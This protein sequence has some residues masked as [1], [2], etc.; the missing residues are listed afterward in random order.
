MNLSWVMPAPSCSSSFAAK[1]ADCVGGRVHCWPSGSP[2]TIC[3]IAFRLVALKI[4]TVLE[5]KDLNS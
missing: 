2:S 4:E 3:D 1:V 5:K